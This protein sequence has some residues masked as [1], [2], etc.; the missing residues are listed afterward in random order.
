MEKHFESV[1]CIACG[2]Q[3]SELLSKR[4]HFGLPLFVSICRDCGLVFLNPRWNK[5][6]YARFYREEYDK[7]Y[8]SKV[9]YN[10]VDVQK[11][12]LPKAEY[13]IERTRS[14]L[15][16]PFTTLLDIGAGNGIFLDY[17]KR[18]YK[19]IKLYAIE[20]SPICINQLV[21]NLGVEL[22]SVD[23]NSDWHVGNEKKFDLIIM[24]SALEHMLNPL[25][26]LCK[27][28]KALSPQGILYVSVP[29][30]MRPKLVSLNNFWYRVPHTYYFSK[31]TLLALAARAGLK[32][33]ALD[34]STPDLWCI[35]ISDSSCDK[36][37]NSV[38]LEQKEAI[39]RHQRVW[40]KYLVYGRFVNKIKR[41]KESFVR[42]LK[43]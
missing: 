36:S 6:R 27:V 16:Q 40:F 42:K 3:N 7:F 29:N 25:E 21:N 34:D 43:K 41:I 9:T 1:V 2:G 4:G 33:L 24:R 20:P 39:N 28:R 10:E 30:M 38:Y 19:D 37:K 17:L 32:P 22:V 14:F 35:F 18:K 11:T 5:E 26:V 13:I 8:R 12:N 23:A 15:P 31:V